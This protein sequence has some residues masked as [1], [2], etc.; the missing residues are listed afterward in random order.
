[1]KIFTSSSVEYREKEL[2]HDTKEFPNRQSGIEKKID[3]D[4][5]RSDYLHDEDFSNHF[6][7]QSHIYRFE[8]PERKQIS[9][10]CE[11]QSHGVITSFNRQ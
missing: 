10:P 11:N 6:D 3:L 5:I 2:T 7:I 8:L 9:L 4:R 1:M